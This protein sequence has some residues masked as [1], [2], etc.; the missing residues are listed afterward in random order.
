MTTRD[1]F[2]NQD[3][4]DEIATAYFAKLQRARMKSEY[5]RIQAYYLRETYPLTALE[6]IDL[7]FANQKD[8]EP[9]VMDSSVHESKALALLN[10]GRTREA[11]AALENALKREEEFPNSISDANMTYADLITR[12]HMI[13][14]YADALNVLSR[15]SDRYIFPIQFYRLWGY[16]AVIFE[17]IGNMFDATKC[18]EKAMEYDEMTH[19][20]LRYHPDLGL[21]QYPDDF[22]GTRLKNILQPATNR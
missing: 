17:D 13:E 15:Y 12:E 8:G 1:W 9:D 2:R 6:L 18:A 16:R 20:G 3:W 14:K 22:L 10:L 7:Y 11:L 5:L 19:S 21:V 4:N